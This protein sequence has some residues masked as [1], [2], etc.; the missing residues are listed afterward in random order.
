MLDGIALTF[1]TSCNSSG[2]QDM[3][4]ESTGGLTIIKVV[5]VRLLATVAYYFYK[6]LIA[7]VLLYFVLV[8]KTSLSLARLLYNVRRLYVGVRQTSL[9][10]SFV[11]Y[12]PMCAFFG[13]F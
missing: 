3:K 10:I 5:E 7:D 8:G 11:A 1:P 6:T 13:L 9:L 2:L 12:A 4:S